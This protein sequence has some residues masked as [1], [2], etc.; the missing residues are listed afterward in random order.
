LIRSREGSLH[1]Y[2]SAESRLISWETLRREASQGRASRHREGQNVEP[3]DDE[4]LLRSVQ[5][6]ETFADFYQRHAEAILRYFL[7]RTFDPEIAA[8][9]TAETFAEAFASRRRFDDRRSG[10]VPW[11][12]TIAHRQFTR[13][14]RR[15]RVEDRARRRIGVPRRSL[16][17]SQ[18]ERI[19]ELIDFE[20]V[21]RAV[22]RAFSLLSAEQR[23]ALTLRVI[24]DRPYE[25][26]ARILSCSQ[27]AARA[28]VS[29]G[30]HRL[31]SIADL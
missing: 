17:E 27:D 30:L 25:D 20:D 12:Y 10:A 31:A 16:S 21:G 8:D 22:A 28:R 2:P 7:H 18:Y 15:G 11:L 26:V 19:E 29:R 24:E 13:F 9:L 3:S 1:G 5:D 6:P 14:L 4:L 23:E